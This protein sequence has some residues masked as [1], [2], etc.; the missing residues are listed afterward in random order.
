MERWLGRFSSEAYALMRFI[1]G[2][3]FACHGA[4]KMLGAFGATRA[5][6]LE[7]QIAGGIELV[8]GLLIAFGL[9]AGYAA[10]L[11]S[12]LMAVAYF[13]VHAPQGFWPIQNHGELAVVFCFVFLYIAT[14]GSGSYSVE[15][16]LKR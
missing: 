8:G 11:A 16:L 2:A 14:R 7:G 15:R 5:N 6:T 10:F 4:E 1:A 3:A 13:K 9:G 12:G